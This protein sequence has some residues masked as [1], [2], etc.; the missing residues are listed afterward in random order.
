MTGSRRDDASA[1]CAAIY[2]RLVG[3][4][5]LYVADRAVAEELAQEA[6]LRTFARWDHVRALD[7]PEAWTW[8]IAMNLATSTFRRRSA[9]R[10]ARQR[11]EPITE[12][13]DE[14]QTDQIAVRRAIGQLPKRQRMVLVLRFYLELSVAETAAQMNA[15]DDAVRSLT[16]RAVAALGETFDIEDAARTWEGHR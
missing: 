8:R 16:K 4:L 10:R 5:A 6:L 1:F 12:A 11:L 14:D 7:T 15:T 9:E 2:G 13:R 3:G